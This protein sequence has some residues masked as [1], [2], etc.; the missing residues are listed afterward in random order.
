MGYL[1]AWAVAFVARFVPSGAFSRKCLYGYVLRFA[2]RKTAQLS[3]VKMA[4][5]GCLGSIF[6][7]RNIQPGFTCLKC[8]DSPQAP[9]PGQADVAQLLSWGSPGMLASASPQEFA[10]QLPRPL[11]KSWKAAP[12][13]WGPLAN[14]YLLNV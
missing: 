5:K 14:P 6:D 13:S 9:A 8:P 4:V 3:G 7:R 1:R 2:F 10:Q 11:R 12:A